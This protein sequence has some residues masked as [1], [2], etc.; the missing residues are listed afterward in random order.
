MVQTFLLTSTL[1]LVKVLKLLLKVKKLN[2]QL[3]T[4]KKV[5]KLKTSLHFN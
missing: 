3:L 4:A 1:S 5:L 2:L